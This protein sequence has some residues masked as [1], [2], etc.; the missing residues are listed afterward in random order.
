MRNTVLVLSTFLL[1]ACTG[2]KNQKSAKNNQVEQPVQEGTQVSKMK[3]NDIWVLISLNGTENI[4][5]ETVPQLEIHVNEKTVIGNDGCNQFS[6]TI[7]S[8]SETQISFGPMRSTRKLC[9]NMEVSNA[10]NKL[11]G[12]TVNYQIEN[13]QLIFWDDN[14]T[15]KLAVYKKID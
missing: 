2:Q 5:S 6:G 13:N 4:L 10:V 8:L 11:L 7:S 1:L 3:L 15:D 9:Q 12:S 14:K